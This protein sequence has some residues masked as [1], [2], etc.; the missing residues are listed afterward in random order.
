MSKEFREYAKNRNEQVEAI[1]DVPQL[2]VVTDSQLNVMINTVVE[3]DLFMIAHELDRL[4][5]ILERKK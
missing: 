2:G 3:N 1:S 5:D 4:C